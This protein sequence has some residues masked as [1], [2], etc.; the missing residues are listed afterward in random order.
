MSKARFI[1]FKCLECGMINVIDSWHGDGNKCIK[2]EGILKPIGD[3][4][5]VD[6]RR[7]NV[8]NN[9]ITIKINADTTQLDNAL[10]KAKELSDILGKFSLR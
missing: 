2:C 4:M 3:A 5:V 6:K 7:S 9:S 10:D 1:A 8:I